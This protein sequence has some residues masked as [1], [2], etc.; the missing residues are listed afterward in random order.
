M[1]ILCVDDDGLI[2][3]ITADLLR[4][5]G[6]DVVEAVGG[7]RAVSRIGDDDDFDLLVTDI[8]MPGGPDGRDLASLARR[9]RPDLPVIYFSGIDQMTPARSGDRVLRKPCTLGELQQAIEGAT[10]PGLIQ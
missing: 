8:H 6:H 2:L 4:M 1:R 3:S 7:R 9:S 10:P 5:L